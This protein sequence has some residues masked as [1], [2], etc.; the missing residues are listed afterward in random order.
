MIS[1]SAEESFPKSWRFYAPYNAIGL[2]VCPRRVQKSVSAI[3]TSLS[4]LCPLA[5]AVM[6]VATAL[7][8]TAFY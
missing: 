3:L 6:L 2:P 5:K 1:H 8:Y 7:G 4:L